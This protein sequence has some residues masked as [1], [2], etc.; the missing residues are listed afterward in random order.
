MDEVR[1]QIRRRRKQYGVIRD[2]KIEEVF[3]QE[4][5]LPPSVYEPDRNNT[6]HPLWNKEVFLMKI[7]GAAI[8]FF[9]TAIIF[10]SPSPKL[11][12]AKMG[13]KEAMGKEFQFAVVADWYEETFGKPLA[14]FPALPAGN[15]TENNE[16]PNHY[17][18]PVAGRVLEPFSDKNQGVLI[19]TGTG[20]EVEAMS[21]GT[22][23]FAGKREDLGNTVIIQHADYTESWYGK[24]DQI[25]VKPREKVHIGKIV[26]IVSAGKDNETGEFYFAIKQQDTFIDP[27]QVM[28]IE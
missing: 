10:Q 9:A 14:L 25:S 1:R 12:K 6:L 7:L 4:N 2:K 15:K 18:S 16:I 17:A 5:E 20:A 3:F 19:E 22:V 8:L 23:V 27:I 13:I 11:E 21:A 28:K 26:G 24:L